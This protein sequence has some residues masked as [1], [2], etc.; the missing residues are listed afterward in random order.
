MKTNPEQDLLQNST[1][2]CEAGGKG[3]RLAK[4]IYQLFSPSSYKRLKRKKTWQAKWQ[5][6][7]KKKHINTSKCKIN[8]NILQM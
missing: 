8:K 2:I 5:R 7:N 3:K 4:I 1:Y 6:N